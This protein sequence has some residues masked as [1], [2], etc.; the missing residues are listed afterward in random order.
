MSAIV[1][2]VVIA[3][4]VVAAA[5]AGWGL[6]RQQTLRRRYGPEYD[7]LVAAGHDGRPSGRFAGMMAAEKE[8]RARERR[9]AEL[10]VHPLPEESRQRYLAEWEEIQSRFV[11]APDQAVR[12]ADELVNRVVHERGYRAEDFEERLADMS[13][14]HAYTLGHYRD[15]HE[16]AGRNTRGEASTE[17]LRQALVHYRAIFADLLGEQPGRIGAHPEGRQETAPEGRQETA[18]EGRQ[19][20]TPEGGQEPTPDGRQEP[21]Q[22]AS[23]QTSRR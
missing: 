18:P 8:L 21:T 3:V 10:D 6:W 19:E 17:Q 7:R 16:I 2:I 9:H 14:E 1:L 12:A 13:V 23:Q 20:T 5:L 4:V 22:Q 15:A 11:D